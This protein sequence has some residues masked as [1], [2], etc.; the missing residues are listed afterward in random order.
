M[1]FLVLLAFTDAVTLEFYA[2][3]LSGSHFAVV[4]ASTAE[5]ALGKARTAKPDVIVID[6]IGIKRRRFC[7]DLKRTIPKR[8]IPVIA[9]VRAGANPIPKW[10]RDT[11]CETGLPVPVLPGLLIEEIDRQ[12]AR[13]ARERRSATHALR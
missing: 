9:L 8:D 3:S 10:A 11:M 2:A 13:A 5:D 1:E 6:G 12:L 4:T 7:R